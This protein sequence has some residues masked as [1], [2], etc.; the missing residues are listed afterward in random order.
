VRRNWAVVGAFDIGGA[1]AFGICGA[2][3][4]SGGAALIGWYFELIP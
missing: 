3:I 4:S 2:A 1:F